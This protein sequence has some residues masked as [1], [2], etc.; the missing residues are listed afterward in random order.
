MAFC[1]KC[2]NEIGDD[3]AFCPKCGE[4]TGTASDTAENK[5]T[6]KT[7][8]AEDAFNTAKSKVEPMLNTKD[9]T[10]DY[11]KADIE[12]NEIICA[13]AYIPILFFLPLVGC[14][15]DSKFA[16]FHAN[17]ALVFFVTTVILSTVSGILNFIPIIGAIIWAVAS[18]LILGGFLFGLINTL[19]GKAK[20][21]PLIGGI[22]LL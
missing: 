3:M 10:A 11:D 4:A 17:Q 18:L 20:E 15:K 12:K 5:D 22:K 9:T 7:S 8:Y 2:G 1:R 19:Q 13:L 14:P 16:R 6:S 21:L